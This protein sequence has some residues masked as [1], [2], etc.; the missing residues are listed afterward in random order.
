MPQLHLALQGFSGTQTVTVEAWLQEYCEKIDPSG[1]AWKLATVHNA[2][3]V[4]R[5][6]PGCVDSDSQKLL[7]LSLW[8]SQQEAEAASVELSRLTFFDRLLELETPALSAAC[9]FVL[10]SILVDRYL[11]QESMRG[12]WHVQQQDALLAVVDFNLLE[13]ALRRDAHYLEFNDAYWASRPA[14]AVSPDTFVKIPLERLMW[15]YARRSD[16]QLLPQRYLSQM[17]SLRRYPRI[18][19]RSMSE[20]ELA[21]L[22]LLRQQSLTFVQ[23]RE[24]T[25]LSLSQLQQLLGALYFSGAITSRELNAWMRMKEK[26]RVRDYSPFGQSQTT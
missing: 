21:V 10:A 2:D 1:I 14:S 25:G 6:H 24:K 13:V 12:V 18:P 19:I 15:E 7:S 22:A 9:R 5:L 23:L 8:S 11:S 4:L 17:I 20:T 16:R 3:A 26:F